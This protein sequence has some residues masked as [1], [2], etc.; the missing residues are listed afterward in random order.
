MMYDE[1]GF[2]RKLARLH[3]FVHPL[4]KI[5]KRFSLALLDSQGKMSIE[6]NV[7][8]G[9]QRLVESGYDFFERSARPEFLFSAFRRFRVNG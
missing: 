8:A 2:S 9:R 1:L 7:L 6:M 5:G 3:R 4:H